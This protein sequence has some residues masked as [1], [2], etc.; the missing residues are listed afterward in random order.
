[1]RTLDGIHYTHVV[2]PDFEVRLQEP[3][4]VEE[5]EGG[6]AAGPAPELS[7]DEAREAG[8]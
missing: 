7:R 6:R 1:M 5:L 2:R 4:T 3:H 8:E